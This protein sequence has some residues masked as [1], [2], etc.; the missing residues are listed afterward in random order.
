MTLEF[1]S[2]G[3]RGK[4]ADQITPRTAFE[5][6]SILGHVLGQRIA[7]GLD[8]R[9]SGQALRAGFL[10]A[11]LQSGDKVTDYGLVPTP[12]LAYQTNSTGLDG[13]VMI[14]ASHNPPEYNGFK[15]FNSRGESLEDSTVFSNITPT[16]RNQE[17]GYKT[18][19]VEKAEPLQYVKLLNSIV[20]RK[21]W[22]VVIDPGNGAT[23]KLAPEIYRSSVGKTTAINS[24]PDPQFSGRGSEPT[25]ASVATLSKVVME[26]KADAGIAFDGDGDRFYMVD[27][28]G[29]C[30]LQ[31]RILASFVSFLAR[32]SKGPFLIPVDASMVVDEAVA[33]YGAKIV[34]GPVGDAKLL[35]EMKR[36]R[37]SFAGEP[38]GAWIHANFHPCPDGL[39]SGIL[40]LQ[41]LEKYDLTVS[42]AVE[43]IPEYS[44]IRRSLAVAKKTT[45][46]KNDFLPESLKAIIGKDSDIDTKF[47]VRVSSKD[48]WVLVR[49]S[50]TEPV[51]RITVESK[52]PSLAYRISKETVSLVKRVYKGL[53]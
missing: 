48:S 18:G 3:V 10:A 34:R 1:G 42:K 21:Q 39:L 16:S 46:S 43:P 36:E 40:Y 2:S 4:Y 24:S 29:V 17:Q 33:K 51:V 52:R 30:P 25:I 12:T 15:V 38:S 53:T 26:S 20:L 28:N 44:M 19:R 27:Q 37:G 41:Q 11:A 9:A 7:L 31:D 45:S 35:V 50:G 6:G 22:R 8:P 47:G 23:S 14:T 49:E 13:G 32:E 5:L